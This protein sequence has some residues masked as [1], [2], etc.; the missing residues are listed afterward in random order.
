MTNGDQGPQTPQEL[1]RTLG[2]NFQKMTFGGGVVGR[3]SHAVWGLLVI[4]LAIIVRLS[5][6]VLL[7]WVLLGGGLIITGAVIWWIKRTHTFAERNPLQAMLSGAEFVEIQRYA[8][9]AKGLPNPENTALVAAT[10]PDV[11]SSDPKQADRQ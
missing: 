9:Q 2:E 5:A 7:N 4:W 11:P 6:N 10:T 8:A 3:T 1:L